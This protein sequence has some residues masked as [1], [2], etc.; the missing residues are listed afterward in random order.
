MAQ[1]EYDSIASPSQSLFPLATPIQRAELNTA[2]QSSHKSP[3]RDDGAGGPPIVISTEAK[4]SGEISPSDGTGGSTVG[5]LS[6]QS[7]MG[8]VPVCLPYRHVPPLEMTMLASTSGHTFGVRVQRVHKVQ[9]VQ[10]GRLT[11]LRAEGCGRLSAAGYVPTGETTH[12]ILCVA[13][14][15]QNVFAV[16]RFAQGATALRAEGDGGALRA[17]IIKKPPIPVIST[18]AERSGEIS[19]LPWY[20]KHGGRKSPGSESPSSPAYRPVPRSR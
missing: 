12:Y 4:R 6:T 2:R 19:F 15:L 1:E 13:P 8:A 18:A 17:Q 11:A 14:L 5:D 3:A 10:R 9:R 20:M 7:I 16:H